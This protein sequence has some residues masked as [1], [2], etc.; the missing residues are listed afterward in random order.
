MAARGKTKRFWTKMSHWIVFYR[1]NVLKRMTSLRNPLCISNLVCKHLA[2]NH[3]R[4]VIFFQKQCSPWY[5]T[6]WWSLKDLVLVTVLVFDESKILP[7]SQSISIL[8]MQAIVRSVYSRSES[9]NACGLS[10]LS[11]DL[12]LLLIQFIFL[13]LLSSFYILFPSWKRI[14][15]QH[16]AVWDYVTIFNKNTEFIFWPK[17]VA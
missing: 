9:H 13:S 12:S 17:V 5:R 14:G 2:M 16:W 15:G 6:A 3:Y 8:T 1:C 7:A 4:R 10:K 11:S